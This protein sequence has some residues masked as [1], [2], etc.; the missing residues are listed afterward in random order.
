[1]LTSAVTQLVRAASAISSAST[2]GS[3]CRPS[4]IWTRARACVRGRCVSTARHGVRLRAREQCTRAHATHATHATHPGSLRL[5]EGEH[6]GGHARQ[7]RHRLLN[8]DAC[9]RPRKRQRA[10]TCHVSERDPTEQSRV[11]S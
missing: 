7:V 5:A 3:T 8:G 2:P 11:V 10:G 9:A 1:L 6:G 4:E